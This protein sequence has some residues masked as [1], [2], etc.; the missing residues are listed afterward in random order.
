MWRF[1][2]FKPIKYGMEKK[3][4]QQQQHFFTIRVFMIP[5]ERISV[6][7]VFLFMGKVDCKQYAN[8]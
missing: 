1:W 7:V 2:I 3:Q 6:C 5:S 8:D 4:Q